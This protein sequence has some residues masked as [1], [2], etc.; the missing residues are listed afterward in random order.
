M[1][2]AKIPG[3][4]K[5]FTVDGKKTGRLKQVVKASVS[6]RHIGNLDSFRLYQHQYIHQW[7]LCG[8][9]CD[10]GSWSHTEI[11]LSLDRGNKKAS[12][13]ISRHAVIH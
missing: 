2:L 6:A 7:E 1:L 3:R 11:I 9:S 13:V 12:L 10:D 4:N 5:S 8:S